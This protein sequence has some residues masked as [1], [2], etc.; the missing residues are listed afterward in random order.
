MQ[1]EE[2]LDP[3]TDICFPRVC[4]KHKALPDGEPQGHTGGV[5]DVSLQDEATSPGHLYQRHA[6]WSH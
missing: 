1:L 3:N 6:Q 4:H 2:A 5:E